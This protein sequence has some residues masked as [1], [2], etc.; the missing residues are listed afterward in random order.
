MQDPI[1][2][3]SAKMTAAMLISGTIG[4]FVLMSGQ[5]VTNVVFWRCVF[6]AATLFMVCLALGLFSRDVLSS[7]VLLLAML[8]GVAIVLNWLL[9]FA[10]YSRASISIA[11]VVYNTQP[12]M[13]VAFGVFLFRE[14]ITFDKLGWLGVAFAGMLLIVQARG[15]SAYAAGTDYLAGV[16]LA[17]GAAF[18]Y[19]IAAV[20]A[21]YLKG[22]PPH[23]IAFIQVSVGVVL[24]APLADF[25]ALP[26]G[27]V[28]WS[29]LAALGIVHTGLMYVLL[30][31]AIQQLPTS[32]TGAL[33]FIYP[34]AAI[35]VDYFAFGHQLQGIQ[36]FGSAAILLAAAGMNLGWSL[37]R[38]AKGKC[39]S[40]PMAAGRS[41]PDATQAG[42]VHPQATLPVPVRDRLTGE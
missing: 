33:S 9:L 6:G 20:V 2:Q 25:A 41:E 38:P 23:L 4:W 10:S 11:T 37:P 24:L 30:Y 16:A 34:V 7:R 13:L 42:L 1:L 17:L 28:E 31:G 29:S 18:L 19:A 3:G 39:T 40:D 32:L 12:F 14:R 36:L 27:G 5:G 26:A 15:G 21:K 8:G 35:A 22:V